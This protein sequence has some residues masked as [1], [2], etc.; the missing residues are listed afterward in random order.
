MFREAFPA[1]TAA[2][3]AACKKGEVRVGKMFV[4]ENRA[5]S[6]PHWII[7]FPTKKHWRHPSKFQWV[8]D[9]LLDDKA[10]LENSRLLGHLLTLSSR[11][12]GGFYVGVVSEEPGT[13]IANGKVVRIRGL[14]PLRLAAL[15]PQS[16]VSANSTICAT[17]SGI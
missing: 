10:E 11:F 17:R 14:E 12:S 2:Y 8:L 9:G 15:P 7:N 1:N 6:G 3:E 4:T 16:S 13:S 5:L